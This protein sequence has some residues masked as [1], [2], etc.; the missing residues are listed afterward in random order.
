MRRILVAE[1][2]QEISS[3]NPQSSE[4]D[5]FDIHVG[6]DLFAAHAQAD[7]CIR[8]AL[9]V[10]QARSD[11][12]AIPLYGAKACSAGPLSTAGFSRIAGDLLATVRDNAAHADAM[13]FCLHGA[14]GAR[15]ELD[16]EGYLLAQTRRLLGTGV[17]IVI[18]LDLHGIVTDRMLRNCDA[19]AV[20][21]TYPHD[22]FIDTGQRAARLLLRMLDEGVR[23]SMAR[24]KIPA[25]VRG[26]ELITKTGLYGDVINQAKGLE[27]SG[28]ALAAAV[29]IGNPF[30]DVPEL[31]SQSLVVTDGDSA[32]AAHHAVALA[33]AFWAHH[34]KMV[35][36]LI[37]LDAAIIDAARRQG[38]VTFTDAADAPSSGASG[39][40]NIILAGVLN[41]AY[42]GKVIMPIVDAP[43][44]AAAHAA[45]VGA[46]LSLTLGGS[47]DPTRFAPLPIE[48]AV[49]RLSDGHYLHQVSN[50]PA[51]AG[52]CAVLRHAN[53]WLVVVSRPVQM[54]DQAIFLA[55]DLDPRQA[56]LIVVKSPGAY[57]RFFT[58]AEI[59][60]VVDV[61]GAT[62]AN[63]T[64]LGHKVCARPMFPLDAGVTFTPRAETYDTGQGN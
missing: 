60:Y 20:Y 46:T 55:H 26:P 4:Y 62:S 58:F 41:H 1:C 35:A 32:R 36:P 54:M 48:V 61:P 14:M 23:P 38:A 21:H 56:D 6:A 43:A 50:L 51:R 44:A 40:S 9:D 29:L 5:L 16:P 42:P 53:I 22:D 8:G 34:E 57:A 47:V 37:D 24:V 12:Q 17:P 30:T 15:G 39:D 27:T 64:R 3:F 25:L 18:S 49:E 63:L 52:P 10:F 19:V 13:Y 33:E 59:N 7:T 28:E 31:C 2:E 45:G 11:V